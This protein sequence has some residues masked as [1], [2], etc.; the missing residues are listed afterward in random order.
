MVFRIVCPLR[1]V[2][3]LRKIKRMCFF[4][5]S[6]FSHPTK[7]ETYI[8]SNNILHYAQFVTN[9]IHNTYNSFCLFF[10]L[11][12]TITHEH[13]RT[14][15]S[16]QDLPGLQPSVPASLVSLLTFVPGCGRIANFLG[17]GFFG[18]ALHAFA[19]PDCTK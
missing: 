9:T 11:F 19:F 14:S 8:F 3:R 2:R 18:V 17:I 12:V 4:F 13:T 5:P 16:Q 7:N 6:I 10:F 1:Q 15:F